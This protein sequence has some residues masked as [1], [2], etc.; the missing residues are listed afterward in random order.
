MAR[1]LF[2]LAEHFVDRHIRQ[3]RGGKRRFG[4]K[5]VHLLTRRSPNEV[6]RAGN[7]L[8]TLESVQQ[9]RVLLLLPDCAEFAAAYFATMKIGAIAV[10]TNT[11]LRPSDYAYL[12]DESQATALI[13]HPAAFAQVEPVLAER[14][15]LRHVITCGERQGDF[16]FWNDLLAEQPPDLAPQ[17]TQRGG[18]RVLV[19]D[20]RQHWAR[21]RPR[22]IA[23]AIGCA[24][25]RITRVACW[26]SVLK[27]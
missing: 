15:S 13:V 3:G 22:S 5:I 4:V 14:K 7:G 9:K 11:S 26:K 20:V 6:N 24:V 27:T 21:R 2:N 25:A 10:P 19:M 23:I 17:L 16:V 1:D 18:H 8:L 12:L